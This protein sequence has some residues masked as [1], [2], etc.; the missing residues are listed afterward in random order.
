MRSLRGADGFFLYKES[1][2]QHLHTIKVQV[3][4]PAAGDVI[5]IDEV[6]RGLEPGIARIPPFHWQLVKM[7]ISR[8]G[9]CSLPSASICC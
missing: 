8:A 5:S 9:V 6:K 4:E 2:T 3:I 1:R 7:P